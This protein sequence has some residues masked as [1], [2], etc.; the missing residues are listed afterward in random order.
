MKTFR[1]IIF[2]IWLPF[3]VSAQSVELNSIDPITGLPSST[4]AGERFYI[5]PAT[6]LP[7][8]TNHPFAKPLQGLDRMENEADLVFKGRV[9]ST[10]AVTNEAFPG[11]G[12]PYATKFEVFSVFK[13]NV[14]TNTIM[15]LHITGEPNGWGGGAPPSH[16]LF[17]VG[18]SYIVF[19]AKADKPDYLYSPSSD[20]IANS[21][22]FRQ[23]M[24]GE[25]A[26]LNLDDRAVVSR[27]VKE[28]LW[29]E[30]NRLL[31]SGVATNSLYAIQ[32][33][34]TMSKSC[35][36]TWGHDDDFKREEVLKAVSPFVSS[37]DDRVAI[38]TIGCFQLG[39]NTGT[40]V[41][42]QGG[43]MPVLHSGFES[44]PECVAL[45][46][47]YATT[48]VDVANKSPSVQRRLAAIAAFSCTGFPIVS[49]S[50]PQWLGDADEQ[51]RAQ[52]VL[53]L[54]SFPGEFSEQLLRERAADPSPKVR[55]MV[56]NAI[57]D[58]KLDHLLP[59]LVKLFSEPVGPTNPIP[60]LTL[61]AL[62][63]GA[64]ILNENVGD[65][66]TSAGYA[67]LK[68]D[69]EQVGEILKTN[70]SDKGF[71]LGFIRKLAPSGAEPYF[72]LLAKELKTH[73]ADS[74]Q[75]AAKNG[76]HWSLSYWLSGNFGW[77]WDT[78]F[79]Y[80]SAQ[81]REAL[82]N[83]QF[84]PMLEALQIA[85]DPGDARTRSLYEFFLDKGIIERA[86][87]LRR[88]IIR[89]MEDKNINRESFGFPEKLKAFDEMDKQ[90]S[91]K[92]GLGL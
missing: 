70:I 84:A 74:E 50:L 68:F 41:T 57:G 6:G 86:K 21:H 76:F 81:P 54:P 64:Q 15:F 87:E 82:A 13:G 58:G 39:G 38:Y 35:P 79:A 32:H 36:E 14:P 16:F 7:V 46:S 10:R 80:V 19:A 59:T 85:D 34:N 91:L 2:L 89:R 60:P 33:L 3:C 37:D 42:D 83:P 24:N 20:N 53:L 45:V 62:Q 18:R 78:L 27:S 71:G 77:A 4:N 25:Y 69:V 49:N 51:V 66:H 31:N 44:Q 88:G 30:F 43:W 55:A 5:D 26:F 47:P 63:S 1:T 17:E 75:E 9:I 22:E 23:P 90:H 73:T 56:A 48:L 61:E 28:T 72:P 8:K 52:A 12:K 40:F 29:N 65:V 11:W 92:P 67:L